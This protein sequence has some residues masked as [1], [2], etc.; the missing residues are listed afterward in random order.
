[1]RRLLAAFMLAFSFILYVQAA[2][3]TGKEKRIS[4]SIR[5]SLLTCAAGEEIYSLYGHTAIRYENPSK[6]IDVVYNY[7]VFDF[8]TP[9]FALR[10][11][12]GQTDYQLGR[13][14]FDRFV[15]AYAFMGRD[16]YQQ[17]LNL[18]QD[19]K[20]RLVTLLEETYLP[21]NRIYRYN[22][23]YDNCA[24]RPRDIIE[25]AINGSVSYAE[26]AI[27]QDKKHSFRNLLHQYNENHPWARFGIDLCVGAKGD[28][29]ATFRE[30]MFIPFYVQEFFRAACIV[31]KA[32]NRRTLIS[33]EEKIVDV[34]ATAT[35][36][37]I[38]PLQAG[39]ILFGFILIATSCSL[40][41]RQSWWGIDLALFIMAGLAGCILAF[42]A[43]FSEH[44]A[45]SPNYLLFVF[46]PFHLLALPEVI[47]KARKHKI[48]GYLLANG[49]VLTL[50]IVLW[51][52]IPQFIPPVILPLALCLLIRSI[53]NIVI[54]RL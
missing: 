34:E 6:G 37:G 1:M 17:V 51:A 13:N 26:N 18:T 3:Q 22:F 33:A 30:M 48:S 19:E 21:E 41:K 49:I 25:R 20:L 47:H 12:L 46:H 27:L 52:V 53:N 54:S 11:A 40:W 14:R 39:W 4:D 50:F 32:G 29:P 43:F 10:F 9:N 36:A 28:K 16:V 5:I 7:G 38:T 23:F 35:P 42:L 2:V 44:P 45:M 15:A 31:D 8:D 24:T